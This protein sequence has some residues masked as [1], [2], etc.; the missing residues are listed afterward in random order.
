MQHVSADDF[1][2]QN[3]SK[4]DEGLLVRFYVKPKHDMRKSQEEGRP[5]FVDTEY[6][7]IRTPGSRDAVA[8]PATQ[9]DINRFPRHYQA[10]KDRTDMPEEGTPLIEWPVMTRSMA[11]ELSFYNIKTV[12]QLIAMPD[13]KA[14]QFMGLMGLKH[15]AKEWLELT[16]E[17]ASASELKDELAKRDDEIAQLKAAVEALQKPRSRKKKVTKKK[18]S[19]KKE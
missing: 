16:K 11:E 1:Q 8:R 13:E 6:V 5:V 14:Q 3:Q 18:V 15:Q 7:E 19:A 9:R 10:F 2:H 4:M 17:Y 12:E